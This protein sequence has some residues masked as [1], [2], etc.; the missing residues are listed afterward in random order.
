ML[1]ISVNNNG[2]TLWEET[3]TQ[4]LKGAIEECCDKI[5]CHISR[6]K[7]NKFIQANFDIYVD[8]NGYGIAYSE[9]LTQH[10]FNINEIRTGKIIQQTKN[11]ERL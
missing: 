10:G 7:D 5:I 9:Y 1:L 8:V 3:K 4:K 11:V 6:Y 2:C